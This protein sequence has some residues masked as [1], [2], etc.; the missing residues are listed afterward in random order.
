MSSNREE[1][2]D[3]VSRWHATQLELSKGMHQARHASFR[4]P[5]EMLKSRQTSYEEGKK[6]AE[7]KIKQREAVSDHRSQSIQ[8]RDS[9]SNAASLQAHLALGQDTDSS[10]VFEKA[11]QE[12]VAATSKGD[13]REDR[14]IER[15]IRASVAEL[16]LASKEGDGDA[17]VRR[18][19]EASIA[20]AT[21]VKN[22][23][24]IT[25]L[26]HIDETTD[27]DQHLE[28]AL[29]QSILEHHQFDGSQTQNTR[30]GSDDSGI[31]TDDD[32]NV[33]S[34][35]EMSQAATAKDLVTE[36]DKNLQ[37][38]IEESKKAHEAHE[39]ELLRTETEE[40][41]VLDFV[42]KQSEVEEQYRTLKASVTPSSA[43]LKE[44]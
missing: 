37:K 24:G 4:A 12:S 16:Q 11:I 15:A 23:G 6:T 34:A 38:A 30:S 28:A 5:Q 8:S 33:K 31:A 18:A 14:M 42:K 43:V 20:E 7:G 1:R 40:L 32:E 29:R 27:H 36:S 39:Q 22:E 44:K 2:L 25:A 26:D 9:T 13:P 17:A 10:L 19:I 35:L 3:V 21:R 41:Q